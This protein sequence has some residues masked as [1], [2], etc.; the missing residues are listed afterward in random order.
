[1][2][3]QLATNVAGSLKKGERVIVNGRLRIRDWTSGEKTGTTVDVE[4]DSIGHDLLWGTTSFTRSV[5][6]SLTSQKP[7]SEDFP[8]EAALAEQIPNASPSPIPE[9]EPAATPF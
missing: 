9:P 5:T 3:R 6:S 2:F 7:E 4:A 8:P 1:M